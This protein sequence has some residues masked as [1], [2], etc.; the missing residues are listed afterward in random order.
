MYPHKVGKKEY[1]FFFQHPAESPAE[2]QAFLCF[3]SLGGGTDL[4]SGN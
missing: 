3:L 2:F 4:K 1:F